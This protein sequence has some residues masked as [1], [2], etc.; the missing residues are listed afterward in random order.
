M[1]GLHSRTT[2]SLTR[3]IAAGAVSPGSACWMWQQAGLE[4]L[5]AAR[6]VVR[7]ALARWGLAAVADEVTLMA[8]EL[9]A[10]ACVHGAPPVTLQLTLREGP[11]SPELTCEVTDA[12]L[13]M[14]A[15][16][17][18]P[19]DGEH[20]RGLAVV[21]AFADEWGTR[22]RRPGT[23]AWFRLAVPGREGRAA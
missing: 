11:A 12:G 19:R 16:P 21:A 14:S 2:G 10:N 22:P 5:G 23:A 18:A 9:V 8:S 7:G 4:S 15:V 20:G 1:T 17:A 6:A 13:G 3:A